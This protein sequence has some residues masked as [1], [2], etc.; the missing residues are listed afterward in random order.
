MRIPYQK[1]RKSW[2]ASRCFIKIYK[3]LV[4]VFIGSNTPVIILLI[5]ACNTWSFYGSFHRRVL[6]KYGSFLRRVLKKHVTINGLSLTAPLPGESGGCKTVLG[7]FSKGK[8]QA[9]GGIL[10]NR[11]N[12]LNKWLCPVF[13]SLLL[14]GMIWS[15]SPTSWV[16]TF[17]G[18][19]LA[20]WELNFA[21]FCPS[22]FWESY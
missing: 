11:W 12:Q 4:Q 16:S 22:E 9:K 18:C 5:T 14:E 19:Y 17:Q 7:P 1:L 21:Y 10:I 3:V 8:L 15:H 20:I 13:I 6:R 2:A